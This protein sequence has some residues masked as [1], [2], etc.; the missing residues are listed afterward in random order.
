MLPCSTSPR[1]R[2]EVG[3]LSG[4]TQEI[5]RLIGRALRASVD[6]S[7]LGERTVIVDCDVIQADGGTRTAAV[8]GGYV[9]LSLA[10]RHLLA[11]G[12][13]D[14]R[15]FRLPV[16][17]ISV[18]LVEGETL[19]DLCYAEDSRAQADLNVAMNA[20]GE[21]IEVQVTAESGTFTRGQLNELLDLAQRGIAE[22]L[23]AQHE[24]LACREE[25]VH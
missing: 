6:L 11:E 14:E 9:A 23:R 7:A 13:I 24:A 25:K 10:L 3:G 21:L 5:R 16:A 22:L 8:T 17:A 2:R 15:A 20:A 18:G 4:R 12:L 1:S 19:L